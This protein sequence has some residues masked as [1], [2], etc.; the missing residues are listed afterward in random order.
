MK[1]FFL[2]ASLLVLNSCI[3]SNHTDKDMDQSVTKPFTDTLDQNIIGLYRLTNANGM[4]ALVTNYGATVVSLLVADKNGKKDDVVFGYDSIQGYYNGRAYF[5]CVAGRYANRIANGQFRLDGKTYDLAKNNGPN[6]LHGGI[7][8]FDKVVWT[9]KQDDGGLTL[10]YTSKDGEE[11]YPG[12]LTVTV[13]YSLKN[14][15]SL[16][17]DYS[18]VTDKATLVNVTNHSYF[19]LEG[20]GQ[21]DILDHELQF[22]ADGFTP[23]DST[24]IPTGEIRKVAGTPFDFTSPHKIGERINDTSDLQIKYGLGYDHN[25]VLNGETGKMK[26]AARV[27]A[28]ISGRIMEVHTTE[29]G[30]QFYSG[31]FLNGSEKGKGSVYGY[32]TGFCLETQHFPDS[33][34]QPSF[35]SAVLK[36][37][38]EYRSTT[39]FKFSAE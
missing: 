30:V 22:N 3:L 13:M 5:G 29:P 27:K 35:P 21:G 1:F 31:N 33:P 12:N 20:Q 23:V 8:G 11:G 17:I 32:R 7:K 34:N 25:F 24:L 26:L 36:P 18:A 39:V 10:T 38:E 14:D 9:A 15:N 2:T 37:G 19:N 16:Q 6:S 28:P 4:E